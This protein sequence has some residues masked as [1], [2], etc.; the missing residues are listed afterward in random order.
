[1]SL[2]FGLIHIRVS[3]KPDAFGHRLPGHSIRACKNYCSGTEPG[4]R[5]K[6]KTKNRR[7]SDTTPATSMDLHQILHTVSM[8]L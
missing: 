5:S 3:V 4:V 2:E 7:K 1:M 6:L 8:G